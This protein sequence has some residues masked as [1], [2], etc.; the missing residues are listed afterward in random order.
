MLFLKEF[1]CCF[2]VV[3]LVNDVMIRE[4]LLYALFMGA[5]HI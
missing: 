5:K 2:I 3:V 4:P 1:P